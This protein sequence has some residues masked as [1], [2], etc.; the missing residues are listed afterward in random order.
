MISEHCPPAVVGHPGIFP[1][2]SLRVCEECQ[3]DD[4]APVFEDRAQEFFPLEA[5]VPAMAHRLV[6]GRLAPGDAVDE[7]VGLRLVDASGLAFP[8]Y[9]RI[10]GIALDA[11]RAGAHR[12]GD[13]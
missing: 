9:Y 5:H 13:R 6:S 4:A 2:W 10:H 11:F 1:L 7:C 3:V 12:P 8:V